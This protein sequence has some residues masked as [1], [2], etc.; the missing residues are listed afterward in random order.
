MCRSQMAEGFARHIAGDL[1]EPY[2]AGTNHSGVL[3]KDACAAM[4]E[5]GIDI[6][7]QYSKGLGDVPLD[8]MDY[9]VTMGCCSAS[10]L[11][12]VTYAGEKIDWPI[13]DPVGRPMDVFRRVRDDIES[14]V[15]Q[16]LETIWRENTISSDENT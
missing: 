6:S 14:R 10:Q 4:E 13:E 9:V 11:C 5:I 2:S 16:L 8:E 7:R 3:S 15:R 12:P 1:V